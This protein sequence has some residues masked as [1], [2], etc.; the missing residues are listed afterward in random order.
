MSDSEFTFHFHSTIPDIENLIFTIIILRLKWKRFVHRL[1]VFCFHIGLNPRRSKCPVLPPGSCLF[2]AM[3]LL[4]TVSNIELS[5]PSHGLKGYSCDG[6]LAILFSVIHDIF[7]K[8]FFVTM[9]V[10]FCVK[11][12]QREWITH[13]RDFT[14]LFTRDL[15]MKKFNA[16]SVQYYCNILAPAIYLPNT[17]S[18]HQWPSI[19]SPSSISSISWLCLLQT[20]LLCHFSLYKGKIKEKSLLAYFCDLEKNMWSLIRCFFD[21]EP[22]EIPY[23]LYSP[24]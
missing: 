10:K 2:L 11:H 14:K 8:L 23:P 9:N 13:I 3:A 5:L 1:L 4:K 22:C 6:R 16:T 17:D 7:N 24:H 18:F 12:E 15:D 19:C 21:L 20:L